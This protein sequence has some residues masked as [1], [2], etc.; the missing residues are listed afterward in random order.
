MEKKTMKVIELFAG[1]GG[2][3]LGLEGY[4]G[5]SP[6]SGY[7]H[8]LENNIEFKVVYSN[9][10]E[11]STKIQHASIVYENRF[12]G[13][14]HF[15]SDI[16]ELSIKEFKEKC[17]V[18]VGGFP[19]QDYSVANS[20]RTSKGLLGKKGVLW[21]QIERILS[22][23]GTKKPK[24]LIL[25][26]VDR[27][28]KSPAN[29]R[30]RDF[31]VMLSS[32]NDLG[33]TVEWRIINAAEYGLPQRRRRVFIMGYLENTKVEKLRKKTN[34]IKWI[35]NDGIIGSPFPAKTKG[36]LEEFELKG[37]LETISKNYGSPSSKSKSIFHNAGIASKR[38]VQTIEVK[39]YEIKYGTTLGEILQHHNEVESEFWI[40]KIDLPKWKEEKGAKK[41]ER[42]SSS[43]HVYLF[44]EGG[45]NFP[46]LLDLPSRTIITSEGGKSPSRFKHV[47]EQNNKLRRLTP[48]E[49]E[50]LNMFPDDF[51]K[52]EN[53]NHT[54]RAFLM[55]NALVVGI[56]EKMSQSLGDFESN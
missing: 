38:K 39:P 8:K 16:S 10:W 55:G 41:K 49:L 52:I 2:F 24:Y 15:N 36:T 12:G 20:L 23:L 5:Y 9:Q 30:G 17:D 14:G 35:E 13:N 56:I 11:P 31:A 46:D 28:I 45:M 19:C 25:E 48:V 3:R 42:V 7:K 43:G 54:K 50:R 26:N 37:S 4:K 1:V 44:S 21:W 47:I 6:L 18:L 29:Q 32:L 27:L 53:I 51:T 22:E 40:D 34:F 33:Y